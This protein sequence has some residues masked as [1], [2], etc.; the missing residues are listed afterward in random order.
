MAH[1]SHSCSRRPAA[2]DERSDLVSTLKVDVAMLNDPRGAQI[3]S[4]VSIDPS[5]GTEFVAA[6]AY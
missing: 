5:Y 6:T 3:S 1:R 4:V 2:A